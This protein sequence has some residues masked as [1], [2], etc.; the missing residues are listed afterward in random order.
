MTPEEARAYEQLVLEHALAALPAWRRIWGARF[1][2]DVTLAG[3][4]PNTALAL[5]VR[6]EGRIDPQHV[7]YPLWDPALGRFKPVEPG[8][9]S[10]PELLVESIYT[11]IDEGAY[12]GG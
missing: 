3:S 2:S 9:P 1:V 12:P 6:I 7:E 11:W 4:Y 5:T 8:G 10:D